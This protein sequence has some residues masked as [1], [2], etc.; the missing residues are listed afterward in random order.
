MKELQDKR[1]IAAAIYASIIE[2]EGGRDG[3]FSLNEARRCSRG[4]V[5]PSES[6]K[7][8][9]TAYDALDIAAGAWDAAESVLKII[10]EYAPTPA[11][12]E[13]EKAKQRFKDCLRACG[14]K[15]DD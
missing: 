10:G 2:W 1:R 4:R 6:G 3:R 8:V 5:V 7:S 15:L 9:V 11:P 13:S 14:V 12:F